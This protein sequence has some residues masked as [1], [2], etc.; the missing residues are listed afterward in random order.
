MPALAGAQQAAITQG[1]L[2]TAAGTSIKYIRSTFVPDEG[3][4]CFCLFEGS[5][6]TDV[7]KLNDDAKIPCSPLSRLS[8]SCPAA[9]LANKLAR[10]AWSVLST[11]KA[12][13]THKIE[14]EA[15]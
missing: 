11:G 15:V 5:S 13:D 6:E 3:G 14:L 10:I 1:K 12:F 7:R 4:R 8:T 2:M 9:A